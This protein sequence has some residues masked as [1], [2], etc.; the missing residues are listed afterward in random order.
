MNSPALASV[1][2]PS[3]SAMEVSPETLIYWPTLAVAEQA[4]VAAYVENNYSLAE[5]SRALEIGTHTLQKLLNKPVI[6][7]AISEVQNDIDSLDFMNEKWVKA[8]LLKLFPKVMG[9]EAV[10]VVNALGDEMEVRKFMPDIAM[11]ILEYVHPKT[12]AGKANGNTA[13]VQVTINMGAMGVTT[14]EAVQNG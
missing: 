10:P 9:E 8:Q 1:L 3:E 4:F 14:Y 11:R 5:T 2:S 7:R 6:R 13:A 12:T